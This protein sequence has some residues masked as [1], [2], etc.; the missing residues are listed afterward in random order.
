MNRLGIEVKGF[1][2]DGDSRPLS[3]MRHQMRL[4]TQNI[5][6]EIDFKPSYIQDT[7]HTVLK[8]R[9]R[10]LKL[11]ILLPM[12][13]K[14]VSVTHLK[15]LINGTS[16]DVHGLVLKDVCPDDKQNFKSLQKIM[17]PR[18]LDALI[19]NIPDSQAT[20][21]HLKLCSFIESSMNDLSMPPVERI[22][23]IWFAVFFFRIWRKWII[24]S[25][26]SLTNNW[27]TLNSYTCIEINAHSMVQLMRQMREK[28]QDNLFMPILFSSQTCE[29]AF[30]Q[31]RSMTTIN[32]TKINFSILELTHMVSRLELQNEIVHFKLANFDIDFPRISKKPEKCKHY[33]LPSDEE[34][35]IA[36]NAAKCKAINEALK[37]EM[38]VD[39]HEISNCEIVDVIIDRTEVFNESCEEV[40]GCMIDMGSND[41]FEFDDDAALSGLL[42][43]NLCLKDYSEQVD[44]IDENSRFTKTTDRNG[45]S[46]VVR[47][48]SVVWLLSNSKETLSSD[49]LQRVQGSKRKSCQQRLNFQQNTASFG[50]GRL[51]FMAEELCLGQW[52]F[53]SNQSKSKRFQNSEKVNDYIVGAVMGFIYSKGKTQKEKE[54]SWDFASVADKNIQVLATWYRLQP[55][56]EFIRL[57]GNNSFY[58]PISSYAMSMQTPCFDSDRVNGSCRIHVP[59]AAKDKIRENFAKVI[60]TK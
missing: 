57:D 13:C 37:F 59:N 51:F 16:K 1:S 10:F 32:W 23:K 44:E 11:S 18:V 45:F 29:Q 50:K 25:Q 30:R 31:F 39:S 41:P 6:G 24:R 38:N 7:I 40:D 48:S 52:A 54:Y 20:V 3:V 21:M 55:N 15:L 49:R 56:G 58:V 36:I 28:G 46:K 4:R 33:P 14:Q 2:T 35:K 27:I 17:H 42:T 47:K 34:I 26:Y 53:F 60:K 8:L 22:E 43:Q 12:G 19:A 5:F 9:N